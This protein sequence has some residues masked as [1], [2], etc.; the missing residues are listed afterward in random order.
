M[1]VLRLS[2]L[3]ALALSAC[4]IG[5]AASDEANSDAGTGDRA[6]ARE[7]GLDAAPGVDTSGRADAAD[8][9]A[10]R[11]DVR[12]AE[13]AGR[14]EDVQR[15]EDAGPRP[16]DVPSAPPDPV[17]CP[18]RSR[19]FGAGPREVDTWRGDVERVAFVVPGLPDP[20]AVTAARLGYFGYDVDHPGAEGWIVVNGTAPLELPADLAL[21]NGGRTFDLDVGGRT[22]AG[23]NRIEFVA[24][25]GPE[26]AFYRISDVQLS[27][28]ARGLECER[29]PVEVVD[30]P[31][32][33]GVS[34]FAALAP[35]FPREG[36]LRILAGLAR[37]FTT[38]LLDFG[39]VYDPTGVGM[40]GAGDVGAR[41]PNAAH[42]AALAGFVQAYADATP[43]AIERHVQLFL[44]NGPG[45]RR[46]GYARAYPHDPA[47][48]DAAL[49]GDAGVRGELGRY[50]EALTAAVAP[51]R[52]RVS[53]RLAVG[54]E[55]NYTRAGARAV[56]DLAIAAGW[57]DPIGRNPCGCGHG[58]TERVGDFHEDHLH[59]AG[60]IAALPGSL[61]PP[62]SFSNDGWGYTYD[63]PVRGEDLIAMGR[64]AS[65]TGL[66]L[67]V[68]YDPI[69]GYP[70][71][72]DG[73]RNLRF[74][75][76]PGDLLAA[77]TQGLAHAGGPTG[78]GEP[79]EQGYRDA[80]YEQ[81]NNWVLDCRDYAYSARGDEHE[82]CD[83][84]YHPDGTT[85]GRAVF[86]F[87][88]VIPDRYEV[89]IEGRHTINR[90][91]AGTLVI[92]EGVERRLQQR[93]DAGMRFDLHGTHD[94][95][96]TVTVVVDSTREVG[97]DSVRRVRLTP[98]R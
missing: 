51:H 68:W 12:P 60:A 14:S 66:W 63:A 53:F 74:D 15:P 16:V 46:Q 45:Q 21:D 52:D 81:R 59:S 34:A 72:D 42:L 82:L 23:E 75:H 40:F 76:P 7:D 96:G 29:L 56:K 91:P 41:Q 5:G 22:V 84:S 92:V 35:H 78:Q 79:R 24:F 71:E 28:T 30:H 90:N 31:G 83:G 85:H 27:V 69:Q 36:L 70:I 39:P 80:R 1:I 55:D 61:H 3:G 38:I 47:G 17:T 50:L 33:A 89:W 54:L 57:P 64:K 67:H 19:A 9:G 87:D 62:D 4:G 2:I 97:S 49:Q 88:G 43:A 37:P 98:A 25:D 93:D 58:D 11:R 18:F 13:D 77:L 44:L 94:L 95:G 6:D 86:T 20:S 32:P 73:P 26:G 8:A 65:E 10:D 48:L